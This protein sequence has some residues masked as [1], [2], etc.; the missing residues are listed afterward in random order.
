M[1]APKKVKL[2]L[3]IFRAYQPML[4]IVEQIALLTMWIE[5]C[6]SS[7]AEE[8]E[9]AAALQ[10]ELRYIQ[11]NPGKVPQRLIGDLDVEAINKNNPLMKDRGLPMTPVVEKEKNVKR[12]IYKRIINF[13]KRFPWLNKD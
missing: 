8:Y 1:A 4:N 10:K 3:T 5:S 9:M 2:I 12:G 13:F 7:D 6:S 11:K